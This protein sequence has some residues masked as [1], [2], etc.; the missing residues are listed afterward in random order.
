MSDKIFKKYNY[1]IALNEEVG[2]QLVSWVTGLMV[3]FVTLTLAVNMAL[4]SISLTW[5]DQL[6]G[7]LTIELKPPIQASKSAAVFINSQKQFQEKVENI[8]TMLRNSD[9][10]EEAHL[11][12]DVD[13]RN[14]IMPWI[15]NNISLD[16]IPL[17]TLIDVKTVENANLTQLKLELTKIDPSASIDTHSTSIDDL[18]KI[19]NTSSLFVMLITLVIAILAI[20]SISG[21]VR[22]KLMV[23]KLEVETLHLMGASNEHIASQFRHHTLQKTVIGSIA[24]SIFTIITLVSIASVTDTLNANIFAYIKIMPIEWVLII[25]SPIIVGIAIA[26]LTAQATALREISKLP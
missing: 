26:H 10:I 2:S 15:G 25:I 12:T 4:S 7:S 21:M 11:L 9:G 1:D 19:I 13:I 5:V 14:L 17:P 23:H 3:F 8:M 18:Q 16:T 20:I 22:S 24:G 6:S